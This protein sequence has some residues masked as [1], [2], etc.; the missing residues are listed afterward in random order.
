MRTRT[1][2]T[3]AVALLVVGVLAAPSAEARN[4]PRPGRGR[5]AFGAETQNGSQIWTVWP[6]GT[7]LR[8]VTDVDGDASQPDWSP[9]GRLL[10]FEWDTP[11]VGQVAVMNADGSG[12]R[13]LPQSGCEFEGQPVFSA[14]QQRIIY[15]RYDCDVDDSLFTQ[16]VEG[17][18]EQRL[19]EAYPDGQTDPNVSPDGHHISYV[20]YDNGV[21]FQQALTVADADGSNAR[22]LLPPSADIGIKQA[23][24]PDNRHIVFT[25]DANPDPVTGILSA[26][27][28][29][30]SL[31][32]DITML[33]HFTGGTWSAFVGS[34]SP[35]GRWIVFRL[36]NNDTGES[37]LQVMRTDG[38]H[39]HT[40]F[41]QD[42]VR[43][44]G[45]DWG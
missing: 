7:H 32:G 38:S 4:E 11:D 21:E 17:G 27:I 6:N 18:D 28:G 15:E 12:I 1:P 37:W 29:I 42:G 26:N 39:A 3:A 14:D 43:A 23:W 13:T 36:Q 19:T 40:I 24:S 31:D 2:I 10:T 8:H 20:R 22:D 9:D 45:S 34:Y 33:T 41:H 30:A 16:R 44:R 5:I 35:D 25:R